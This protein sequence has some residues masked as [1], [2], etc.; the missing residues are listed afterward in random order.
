M[1]GAGARLVVAA[2]AIQSLDTLQVALEHEAIEGFVLV[3]E[4]RKQTQKFRR[5]ARRDVLCDLVVVELGVA[6]HF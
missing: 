4:T 2:A 6:G 3:D 5:L 1:G